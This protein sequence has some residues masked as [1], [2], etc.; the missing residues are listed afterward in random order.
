M[1]EIQSALNEVF[2]EILA[3]VGV[4]VTIDGQS[5]V[6]GG[7]DPLRAA[8]SR[9]DVMIEDDQAGFIKAADIRLKLYVPHLPPTLPTYRAPVVLDGETYAITEIERKQDSPVVVYTVSSA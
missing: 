7:A 1:N 3:A 9:S 6:Y 2:P 8:V 4:P 5:T